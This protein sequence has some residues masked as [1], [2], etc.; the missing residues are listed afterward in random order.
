MG[1]EI[2]IAIVGIL[3]S[4]LGVTVGARLQESSTIKKQSTHRKNL[5]KL[6]ANHLKMILKDLENQVEKKGN[7]AIFNETNYCELNVG[8]FLY[9]LFT[10]NIHLFS[11]AQ[12]IEKTVT[13]FHHYKINMR[14][15]RARLDQTNLDIA[16][17]EEGTFLNLRKRLQDAIG[18]LEDIANT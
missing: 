1:S 8:N 16:T 10:S 5:A 17:I 15:I 6:C 13:F 9:D 11:D 2:L 18:E 4:L 7:S 14:T 3:G 12:Q